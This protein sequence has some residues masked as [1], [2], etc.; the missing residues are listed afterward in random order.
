MDKIN[1]Y[2]M[3]YKGARALII[4]SGPSTKWIIKYKQNIRTL[5]DVIIGIN[6]VFIEFDSIMDFHMIPEPNAFMEYKRLNDTKNKKNIP[7]IVNM[8]NI[9][10]VECD[11]IGCQKVNID[12]IKDF[13]VYEHERGPGFA[14]V[15]NNKYGAVG[16]AFLQSLH[17]ACILGVKSIFS[18]GSEFCFSDKSDRFYTTK[19]Y[20]DLSD[21][22][23]E[24]VYVEKN[25]AIFNTMLIFKLASDACNNVVQNRIK[26]L[27][28][29]FCD[30]SDG[31]LDTRNISLEQIFGGVR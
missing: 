16:T 7:R 30:L 1:N 10:N 31:L 8:C 22:I 11:T 2:R 17:L 14:E 12:T 29:D 20:S 28:I 5:F 21:G 23:Y 18:I 24:K 25:G 15:Y 26:P 4:G 3:L 6:S 27:G 13:T 9:D 19:V